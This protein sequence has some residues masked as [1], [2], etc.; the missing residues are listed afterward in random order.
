MM[1]ETT[2]VCEK[3]GESLITVLGECCSLSG[4]AGHDAR[5]V[6]RSVFDSFAEEKGVRVAFSKLIL[7][8]A[9][10]ERV[11]CMSPRLDI[12]ALQTEVEDFGH[13]LARLDKPVKIR[14]DREKVR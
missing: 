14:T 10:D 12:F 2:R 1:N 13:C 9:S 6:F 3:N 8:E 7:E 5:E 11:K 4:K